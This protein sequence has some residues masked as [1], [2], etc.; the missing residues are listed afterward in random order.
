M[1]RLIYRSYGGDNL[2]SRPS[3]YDKYVT[4]ASFIRAAQRADL[5]ILYLND[6]PIPAPRINLMRR[7]GEVV[8]MAPTAI[9]M[10]G[11]Y[12]TAWGMPRKLGWPDDTLVYFSEDDYLY[13][14]DAFLALQAA[15]ADLH[16]ATYFS[17]YGSTE[18]YYNSAE[19]R[20]GRV[21]PD[22][23]RRSPDR[24]IGDVTW[25]NIPSTA[26][27]FGGRAG[28]LAMDY[29]IMVQCMYPFRRRYQDHETCLLYQGE[30][31]Y[32]TMQLL[33]GTPN[34]YPMTAWGVARRLGLA[35]FR[36]ALNL[37]AWT[38]RARPHPL[39]VAQ[40]NLACHM[41]TP[42]MTPG[43]D[44]EAI[45]ADTRAWLSRSDLKAVEEAR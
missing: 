9:G 24:Q 31:P 6:G 34:S 19:F 25:V 32:R 26:S 43:R 13:H 44:W 2:K 29:S 11:S 39:Y 37:R 12:R 10:R 3:Y 22:G 7:T 30:T 45:A 17:L 40:P 41:E 18:T 33:I 36:V 38:R 1:I 14:P 16:E 5:P 8:Q 20:S 4:L 27:T 23:F 21:Y 42:V 35:P 15:D 28:A